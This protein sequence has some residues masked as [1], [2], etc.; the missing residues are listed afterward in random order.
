MAAYYGA[1]QL[2][3]RGNEVNKNVKSKATNMSTIKI[4]GVSE[5][6]MDRTLNT[7][8]LYGGLTGNLKA[9]SPVTINVTVNGAADA[10]ESARA[11]QKTLNKIKLNGGA[12]AGILGFN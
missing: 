1:D 3:G 8:R 12:Q 9:A 6:G 2:I 7:N 5:T 11:I 10:R 4:P